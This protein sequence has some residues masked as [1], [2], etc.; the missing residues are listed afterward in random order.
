MFWSTYKR[1]ASV[2]VT[3]G[4]GESTPFGSEHWLNGSANVATLIVGR[5]L[6]GFGVG[7]TTQTAPLYLAETSRRGGGGPS[8]GRTTPSCAPARW[9]RTW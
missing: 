9:R 5:L 8:R 3:V 7:F 6:L 4:N 1:R 2:A